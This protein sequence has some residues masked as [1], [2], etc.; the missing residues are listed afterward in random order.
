MDDYFAAVHALD[1]DSAMNDLAEL[2]R[3]LLGP[4]AVSAG[5]LMCGMPLRILGIDVSICSIGMT[6]KPG[7]EKIQKWIGMITHALRGKTLP[8]G[9]A[10]K[11]VGA[12]SWA[13]QNMFYRCVSRMLLW[14]LACFLF[15]GSAQVWRG[16]AAASVCAAVPQVWLLGAGT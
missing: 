2:V 8:P 14:A 3:L 7:A 13:A 5:K 9:I 16:L 10:S 15:A 12:L 4:T 6:C 11:L 1:M